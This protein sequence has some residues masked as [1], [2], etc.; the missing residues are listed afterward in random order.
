MPAWFGV[1]VVHLRPRPKRP[2]TQRYQTIHS[3]IVASRY[4]RGRGQD[5]PNKNVVAQVEGTGPML[6]ILGGRRCVCPF[7]SGL[8]RLLW[9]QRIILLG[10]G[11]CNSLPT[12]HPTKLPQLSNTLTGP[13]SVIGPTGNKLRRSP[14]GQRLP[15]WTT[16]SRLLRG[17]M[18]LSSC[19][20]K[21][22]KPNSRYY[23]GSFLLSSVDIDCWAA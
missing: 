20:L 7:A 5:D 15:S 3:A 12:S 14:P 9:Q 18:P 13:T 11:G 1:I 23:R 2:P 17:R 21:S 4:H 19:C 16:S 6:P 22:T 10:Q 8:H